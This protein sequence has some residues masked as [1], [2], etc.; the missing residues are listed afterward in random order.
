M[1]RFEQL[2]HVADRPAA[3]AV[4]AG[5]GAVAERLRAFRPSADGSGYGR[6]DGIA[7]FHRLYLAVAEAVG[8]QGCG[9]SAGREPFGALAVALVERYLCAVEAAAA[10]RRAPDCWRPLFQ[11]RRH[12]GVRQAQFALAGL[13]AHTAHDLPLAV[14]DTCRTLRCAPADLEEGFQRVADLLLMIEER[15]GDELMPGPEV[16]EVSDPLVHLLGSWNAERAHEAAWSSV[17]V[18]WRLRDVP[19]LAEE[20]RQRM[21]AGA[22]LVGRCLLTPCG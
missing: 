14:V 13:H 10:G 6:G 19:A 15:T 22:G 20:F 4:P 12:P 7:V 18:L 2:G 8:G 21:D 16:L 9:A 1:V 17:L 11:Y 5:A 3:V